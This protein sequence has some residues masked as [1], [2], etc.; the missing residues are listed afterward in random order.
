MIYSAVCLVRFIVESPAQSGRLKTLIQLGMA[1]GPRQ[2]KLLQV[3]GK[4]QRLENRH[5]SWSLVTI[6][7]PS[8]TSR[9]HGALI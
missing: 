8:Q 5:F 2:N 7:C 9:T 3:G 1:R 4:S 6:C